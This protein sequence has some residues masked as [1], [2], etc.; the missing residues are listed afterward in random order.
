[1]YVHE[2]HPSKMAE[3]LDYLLCIQPWIG[4][5]S[6]IVI[7]CPMS[8]SSAHRLRP[9]LDGLRPPRHP[10]RTAAQQRHDAEAPAMHAAGWL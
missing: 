6:R 9:T 2:E 5:I 8:M 4:I 10:G 7:G 3:G 1:M